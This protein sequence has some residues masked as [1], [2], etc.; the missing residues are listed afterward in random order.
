[1]ALHVVMVDRAFQQRENVDTLHFVMIQLSVVGVVS[2]LLAFL[3]E[4]LPKLLSPYGWFAYS[5]DLAAGT[6]L[7]YL[8]QIKAQ[9]YTPPT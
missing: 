1:F 6:L 5:F 4:P 2:L 3:T 9:K 8:V 7:A